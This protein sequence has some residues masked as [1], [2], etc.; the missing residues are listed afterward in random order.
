MKEIIINTNYFIDGNAFN[1]NKIFSLTPDCKFLINFK[2]D[3]E[4]KKKLGGLGGQWTCKICQKTG[5]IN[6]KIEL[7]STILEKLPVIEKKINKIVK[8]LR[9]TYRQK[10]NNIN[11]NKTEEVIK[12]LQNFILSKEISC[13]SKL[14]LDLLDMKKIHVN[15]NEINYYI[16]KS[17]DLIDL[18]VVFLIQIYTEIVKLT[19]E[20]ESISVDLFFYEFFDK[21]SYLI[22]KL[23]I[24]YPVDKKE[25]FEKIN[26][27]YFSK[28]VGSL[29]DV[30]PSDRDYRYG[31]YSLKNIHY[32]F[33][34]GRAA[35]QRIKDLGLYNYSHT[36]KSLILQTRDQIKEECGIKTK[37][38]HLINEN[39]LYNN[40][41]KIIGNTQIYRNVR[42]LKL[43][44]LE[45][46]LYFTINKK[47]IG[48]EYQ[49]QQHYQPVDF[50]GGKK[51]FKKTQEND[52]IKSALCK[53]NN[54]IL[55]EFPY[56][57]KNNIENL[58]K[59]LSENGIIIKKDN[60]ELANSLQSNKINQENNQLQT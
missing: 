36:L 41:K 19:Q 4:C 58:K 1:I 54:I 60:F 2:K 50:F 18:E 30:Y 27:F 55:I 44:N 49:G 15:N 57:L 10:I 24:N 16:K 17:L 31:I 51:S 33:N 47:K 37:N 3:C 42:M 34:F 11:L 48:I 9:S 26:G 46:D 52:R 38:K 59:K 14:F 56:N 45:L 25:Y 7:D 40:L 6:Y 32:D 8:N 12:F 13:D 53:K 5:L 29:I 28:Y 23:K 43:N 22:N 39:I 21:Y 35:R 20:K